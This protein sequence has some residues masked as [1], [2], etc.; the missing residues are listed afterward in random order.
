VFTSEGGVLVGGHAFNDEKAM[1]TGALLNTLWDGNPIRRVRVLTGNAFLP[2]RRC[3]M[4]IMMQRVVADKLLGDPVLDGIGTVARM[5]M[6]D[7]EST[8][9]SRPF[10]DAP[11]ECALILR[12]YM[13][14][15]LALLTRPPVT[16]P[17]T[18]DVLD[19]PIMT[20]TPDARAMWVSF[21]DAV[22]SDLRRGGELHPIRAFGAK[23]AEHAGRLAAV[24]S[25]YAD[26]DAMEVNAEA[27]A[28]GI[29]LAQHYATEMLRLQGGAAISPDLRLAE[30]LLAWWQARPDPQ[31]H[32]AAIYQTGPGA[33]RDAA[34][35]RRIV[36]ILEEHGFVL[37]LP[38]GTVLEGT[39]R[40]DA[41]E[42]VP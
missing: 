4:H 8:M 27:M 36:G 11:P 17:D 37:R 6:V 16:A 30:R 32:L 1:A 24:L 21:H 10:R 33:M 22:E 31:C 34:T 41:W 40:R 42:L 26:P 14:T 35:A 3:S 18:Q 23:M 25:V 5:L 29:T 9:G 20:L 39:A 15:M 2:G 28:C 12:A 38:A 7:P 19:P 13:D